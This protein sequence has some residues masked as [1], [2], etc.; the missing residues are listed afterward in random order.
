LGDEEV[1][2]ATLLFR[3][4][5][6][7]AS[8][9][10]TFHHGDWLLVRKLRR[11]PRQGE[12]VVATDPREPRRLLV[13]RVRSIAGDRVT[14]QGDHPDPAESTDSRQFGPIAGS[15]VVGRPVLRYAPLHRF[16]FVR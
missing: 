15:A 4:A 7:G 2:P 13:K 11:P 16:G 3:V 5:V 14:L 10:P 6:A 8:M 12:V 9:E 1:R